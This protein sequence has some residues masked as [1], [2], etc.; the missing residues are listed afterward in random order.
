MG[1]VVDKFI[2]EVEAQL[3]EK[4]VTISLSQD[5]REW[6]ADKGFD[7]LFGAR[8]LGRVIQMEL[9]DKIADA[10]L[11]GELIKGGDVEVSLG[12]DTL[13]FEFHPRGG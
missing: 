8:P 7:P 2:R 3:R 11:F 1:R 10:I 4:K 5:S 13:S 12:D 9:K 6:L